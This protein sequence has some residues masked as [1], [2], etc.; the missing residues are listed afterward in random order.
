MNNCMI[1]D[2]KSD[3]FL[4]PRD[5]VESIGPLE[6]IIVCISKDWDIIGLRKGNIISPPRIKK[7]GRPPKKKPTLYLSENEKFYTKSLP[8]L[9]TDLIPGYSPDA[10]YSVEGKLGDDGGLY[11]NIR[12]ARR[13]FDPSEYKVIPRN[14][15][16]LIQEEC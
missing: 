8:C 9:D 10:C 15:F 12:N 2:F 11:F 7:A 13:L 16:L 14:S 3:R 6:D 5:A 1:L 4:I